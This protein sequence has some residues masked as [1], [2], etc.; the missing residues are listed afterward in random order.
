MSTFSSVETRKMHLQSLN[1]APY[2]PRDRL[3][4]ESEQYAMLKKSIMQYGNVQPIVVNVRDDRNVIVGGH[5]RYWILHEDLGYADDTVVVVDLEPE[6]EAV[7]NVALNKSAGIDDVE[8]LS[9]LLERFE[10]ENL[11]DEAQYTVDESRLISE[12][13][14]VID[15]EDAV[16]FLKDIDIEKTIG[17]KATVGAAELKDDHPHRTG[18]QLF[19]MQMVFSAEQRETVMAAINAAKESYA[20]DTTMEAVVAICQQFLID[21]GMR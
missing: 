10:A 12:A 4:P 20:L 6:R 18:E 17:S 13:I 7:L 14:H 2:N 9:A 21:Q 19:T 15:A 3:H 16:D 11:L 5:Q 8:K 1:P